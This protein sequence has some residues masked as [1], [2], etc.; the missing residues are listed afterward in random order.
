M[1]TDLPVII[2]TAFLAGA[3]FGGVIRPKLMR[4]MCRYKVDSDFS[5]IVNIQTGSRNT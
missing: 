5:P 4:A 2:F 1:L 3:I